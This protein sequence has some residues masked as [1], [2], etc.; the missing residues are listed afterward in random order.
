[1]IFLVSSIWAGEARSYTSLLSARIVGGLASGLIEALGPTM[2]AEI[3]TDH[4]LARAMVVYVGAL[5]A[6]ASLGPIIAGAIAQ[7]LGD[8]R[9]F[10]RIMSIAIAVNLVVSIIMLPETTH[11]RTSF[12]GPK[13]LD[14]TSQTT[15]S[16]I[17]DGTRGKMTGAIP[18]T[19]PVP[20]TSP[21]QPL[22]DDYTQRSFSLQ[23]VMLD[24]KAA[25][26]AC[27]EP[28]KF[29]IIPQVFATALIFGLTIGW[30]TVTAIL[31]SIIY[32][33]PPFL[34]D[35][36]PVG[37][38]NVGPL[39]G[40]SIGL[41]VGG[42]LA[43]WL[44]NRNLRRNS[45][46]SNPASRLPAL[47]PGALISPAGCVLIGYALQDPGNY[48]VFCVGWGMLSFGL[49]SSANVLLTYAIDCLPMRA[50]HIGTLVNVT[51]NTI[52]FAVSY[53]AVGWLQSSGP[54][55]QFGTMAGVLWAAYLIV[56]PIYIFSNSLVRRTTSWA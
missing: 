1:V 16:D 55:K 4:Q 36:L 11:D 54:L 51:K 12:S 20:S 37:L 41:P 9:W 2:V 40:L 26:I 42:G 8:W 23:Y 32:V 14:E 49:T 39:I 24:W 46:E 18:E 52:G 44:F 5:A 28:L 7:G 47:L 13:T 29:I 19:S 21:S 43:D 45:S 50:A 31:T 38:L 27:V 34:W 48:V 35:P 33:Y 6:G 25:A 10:Q 3:F 56:I 15:G 30:F 53:G 17:N 22:Q